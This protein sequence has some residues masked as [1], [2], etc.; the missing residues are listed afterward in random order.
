LRCLAHRSG[1]STA[2]DAAKLPHT[3]VRR[4]VEQDR[5]IDRRA[6]PKGHKMSENV[7][8]A[9]PPPWMIN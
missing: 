1:H 2:H 8:L 4:P 7:L 5:E 3:L 9:L 6:P